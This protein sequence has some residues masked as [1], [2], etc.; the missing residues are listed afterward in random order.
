MAS[1]NKCEY[2]GSTITSDER[3]CP[4]C[5]AT[6][7]LFVADLPRRVTDPRTIEELQEYCAERGM[8]LLR[9]RFFIGQDFKEPKAFGIFKD[10]DGEFVVYKNKADGTR[11][12]RYKGT[13]E[14]YAVK[15]IYSKLI[16]ECSSRGIYPDGK[17]EARSHN[18]PERVFNDHFGLAGGHRNNGSGMGC[19][20][21]LV[22]TIIII[23]IVLLFIRI[24]G[25]ISGKWT[26]FED[27]DESYYTEYDDGTGVSWHFIGEDD[28]GNS[29]YSDGNGNG[30]YTD[31]ENTYY[32]SE[33]DESYFF[34]DDEDEDDDDSDWSWWSG[35]DDDDDDDR[36]NDDSSWDSDWDSGWSDW[37]SG[38]SDWDSDW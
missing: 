10:S 4:S 23:L 25:G 6:N 18:E 15:E 19:G 22:C 24:A 7:P 26:L 3:T 2:C 38:G 13:D 33:D 36:Y 34:E 30:Y 31:G 35:G 20:G 12:V 1:T 14:E 28:E 17:P 9:M 8:P 11:S 16:E 29:H 32:Y 21:R 5:G 37:D 27:S